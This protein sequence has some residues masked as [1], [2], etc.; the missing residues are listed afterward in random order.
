MLWNLMHLQNDFLKILL[1]LNNDRFMGCCK[2][3]TENSYMPFVQF[4]PVSL[5]YI[6]QYNIKSRRL[7]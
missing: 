4:P 6:V 1:F 7:S 3:S 2:D 5:Y